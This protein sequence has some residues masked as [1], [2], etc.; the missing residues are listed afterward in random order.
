MPLIPLF[1]VLIGVVTERRRG[2]R[3]RA[4]ARLAHHFLDV[5]AGLPTLKVYGRAHAQ[6][7]A[8]E[9]VTDAYRRET[10]ATLRVAFLSAFAL[11]LAATLSVALVAVEV[12]LRLV[13]GELDLRTGLFVLVLA[14]EAYLPLRQLGLQFHASEEGLQ[15]AAAAFAILETRPD[16]PGGS[17]APPDMRTSQVRLSAVAVDQPDRAIEAPSATDLIARPGEV[18][19]LR[20]PSGA[21]KSTLLAI[22]LGF[23]APSTGTAQVVAADGRA[24]ALGDLDLA[25]WRR[26]VAWVPQQP[27]FFAGTVAD[28]VRLAAPEA[29]DERI[30]AALAEVGLGDVPLARR[31]GERGVGL[32]SG[33]R[34]RLAVAR[35]LLRD[36]P[37]VL[38]DEPTAGL[39]AANEADVLMRVQTAAR[40]DHRAVVLA[41]HRPAAIAI[42]DRVVDVDVA[43]PERCLSPPCV[44]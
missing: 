39:D 17:I 33:Q 36:A 43:H 4:L 9:R 31:L 11:E 22:L 3:W 7:A 42:A 38:L 6:V 10:L 23:T 25:L 32:S 21:G 1:M 29:S 41:A 2:R 35:A 20:G 13:G 18:V 24:V 19:V 16:P 34:R 8:L 5:V 27:F 28:N 12:G 44:R 40:R 14:P 37:L 15:A 30:A 26:Q